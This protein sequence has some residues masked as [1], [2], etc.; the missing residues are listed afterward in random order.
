MFQVPKCILVMLNQLYELERK[1][2]KNGDPANLLRNINKMKESLA[3]DGFPSIDAGGVPC[4]VGLA[5]EDPMGQTVNETRID[6]DVS[7][8]GS[9]TNNLVVVEVTKPI[10]HAITSDSMGKHYKVIQKGIVVAESQ[11][12]E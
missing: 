7:I 6:L 8:S 9:C 3:E 10:V 5:Y 2:K 4:V 11:K 1:I 12:G